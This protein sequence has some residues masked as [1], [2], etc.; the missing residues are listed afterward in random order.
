M[1]L[2][3]DTRLLENCI[4]APTR[5]ARYQRYSV[6]VLVGASVGTIELGWPSPSVKEQLQNGSGSSY[7]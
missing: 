6:M 1:D 4:I 3:V 7:R 5:L 2:V